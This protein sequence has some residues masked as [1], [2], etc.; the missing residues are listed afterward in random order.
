MLA[1]VYG[2]VPTVGKVRPQYICPYC[3]ASAQVAVV[4]DDA[5]R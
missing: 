4:P 1:A 2:E 5:A 3:A